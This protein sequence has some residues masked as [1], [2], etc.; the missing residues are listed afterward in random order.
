MAAAKAQRLGASSSSG[1]PCPVSL[2]LVEAYERFN[3][4]FALE[5]HSNTDKH[6]GLAFESMQPGSTLEGEQQRRCCIAWGRAAG[7]GCMRRANRAI[8]LLLLAACATLG[9]LRRPL[10]EL[11]KISKGDVAMRSVRGSDVD[12]GWRGKRQ[13]GRMPLMCL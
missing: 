12:G 10:Y 11:H 13:P 2:E 9:A 1:P 5:V 4:K 6:G 8:C 3:K 7:P